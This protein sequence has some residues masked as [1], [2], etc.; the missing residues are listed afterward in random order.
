MKCFTLKV[1][2]S[3]GTTGTQLGEECVGTLC[4]KGGGG[5]EKGEERG[6]EVGRGEINY[7]S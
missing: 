5:G 1:L 3:C 7:R 2:T 4:R 6:K